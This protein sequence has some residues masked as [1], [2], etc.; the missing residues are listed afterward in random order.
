[1]GEKDNQ[2]QGIIEVAKSVREGRITDRSKSAECRAAQLVDLPFFDDMVKA[3][4]R[5]PVLLQTLR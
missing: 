2:R 3:I 1:M 5:L 4:L